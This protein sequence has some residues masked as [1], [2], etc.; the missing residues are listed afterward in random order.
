MSD[1]LRK[2]CRRCALAPQSTARAAY[3]CLISVFPC[4]PKSDEGGSFASAASNLVPGDTNGVADEFVRKVVE[5]TAELRQ[6]AEGESDVGPM[7]QAEQLE[8]GK[9]LDKVKK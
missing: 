6:G 5:K 3:G 2:Q 4:P 9:I 1:A 8:I 7:I